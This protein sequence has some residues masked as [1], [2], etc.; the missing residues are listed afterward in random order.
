[1]W[2]CTCRTH[3][4]RHTDGAGAFHLG[5]RRGGG[6]EP[7]GGGRSVCVTRSTILCHMT[8]AT[9]LGFVVISSRVSAPRA[10]GR[11]TF[12][13]RVRVCVPVCVFFLGGEGAEKGG[14][15]RCRDRL[16]LFFFFNFIV[17][18][19]YSQVVLRIQFGIIHHSSLPAQ[20]K[21]SKQGQSN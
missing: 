6:G 20:G 19:A 2:V 15:G 21:R 5:G 16:F 1:M 9:T 7:R 8:E 17:Y 12:V 11:E 13:Q 18:I 14:K 4:H 10:C 3:T